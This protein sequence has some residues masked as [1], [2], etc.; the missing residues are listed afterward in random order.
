MHQRPLSFQQRGTHGVA[1]PKHVRSRTLP[2]GNQAID[3]PRAFCFFCVWYQQNHNACRL[4]KPLRD[5]TGED[6]ID[7]GVDDDLFGGGASAVGSLTRRSRPRGT[8]AVAMVTV[9]P[10]GTQAQE[11]TTRGSRH[12][13]TVRCRSRLRPSAGPSPHSRATPP[14]RRSAASCPPAR[15]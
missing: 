13:G 1:A 3:Q 15:R 9:E 11:K 8:D 4:L 6:V 5:G 7:R 12:P 14:V 2:L 10:R